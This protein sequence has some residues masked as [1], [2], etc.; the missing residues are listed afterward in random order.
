MK[1]INYIIL[2]LI[3]Y[4]HFVSSFRLRKY[5]GNC[6]NINDE[7]TCTKLYPKCQYMPFISCCGNTVHFCV[8][9]NIG[10]CENINSCGRNEVTGEVIEF[11]SVC[12][13]SRNFT[14]FEPPRD[15]CGTLQCEAKGMVCQWGPSPGNCHGTSCCPNVPRCVGK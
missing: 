1:L 4:I 8:N 10:N 15:T 14:Y 5:G 9:R 3:I 11:W 12:K 7:Q 2:I 13:P 6:E